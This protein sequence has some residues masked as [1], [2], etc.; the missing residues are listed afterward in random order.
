[1]EAIDVL[2]RALDDCHSAWVAEG[3]DLT[4]VELSSADAEYVRD[5]FHAA[6]GRMPTRDEWMASAAGGALYP[7]RGVEAVDRED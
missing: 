2:N 7:P 5:A 6:M 3:A 4:E 1:M